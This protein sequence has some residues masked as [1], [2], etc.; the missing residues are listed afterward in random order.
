MNVAPLAQ[1]SFVILNARVQVYEI[2][3]CEFRLI[4]HRGKQNFRSKSFVCIEL[5]DINVQ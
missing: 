2:I 1:P 4:L 5:N 3:K